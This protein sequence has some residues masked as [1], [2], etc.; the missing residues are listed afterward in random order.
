MLASTLT[1]FWSEPKY[2]KETSIRSK[3]VEIKKLWEIKN[4]VEISSNTLKL[5]DKE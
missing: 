5:S 1:V 4:D 2:P 3:A